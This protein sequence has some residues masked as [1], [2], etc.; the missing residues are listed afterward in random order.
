METFLKIKKKGKITMKVEQIYQVVN[1]LSKQYIGESGIVQADLSNIVD[2]GEKIV[3]LSNMDKYTNSLI[4]QIG[5]VMFVNRPYV[6]GVPSMFVDSWEYGAILEKVSYDELPKAE[7]NETWN[8][9]NGTS[10]DV[11]IFTQPKVSAKFFS[12]KETYDV[13][14]SFAHRQVTSAFQSVTQLNA[15]FSMIETMIDSAMTVY[16]D[17]LAMST[18]TTMI[19]NT[20]KDANPV[21]CVNL[22]K[23]YNQRFSTTLTAAKALTTP[24]FIRFATFMLGVYIDRIK[25]LSKLFNIGGKE[26]HTPWERLRIAM[27]TELKHAS[28]IYLQSDTFHSDYVKLPNA[29]SIAFWQGSGTDFSFESTSKINAKVVVEQRD[30]SGNITKTTANVEQSGILAVM[31][32]YFAC[33]ITNMDRR[34]TTNWNGRAEFYNNWYKFDCGY[35]NDTDENFVVFYIADEPA[36]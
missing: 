16:N 30:E 28:E 20:L 2:L 25:T 23:L 33:A 1:A 26:R 32:D 4:D 24:E 8:L 14:M 6:G 27:H 13:P 19:A 21:R 17:E 9:Q 29:D 35:F 10:Y 15:F 22:L 5:K 3:N 7:I 34:V 18:L 11:N 31:F 12:K 36:A